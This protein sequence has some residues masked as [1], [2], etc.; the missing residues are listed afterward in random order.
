[1]II[2]F[3]GLPGAGKSTS[4]DILKNK[5]FSYKKIFSFYD[6]MQNIQ[7]IKI[8]HI[9]EHGFIEFIELIIYLKNKKM[10]YN[11]IKLWLMLKS[12]F[13]FLMRSL[14]IMAIYQFCEENYKNDIILVD[15]GIVQ[16]LISLVYVNKIKSIDTF[17]RYASNI[18][19]R[20]VYYVHIQANIN[21]SLN[22]LRTRKNQHGRL[23]K[24]QS[25]IKLMEALYYQNGL[26]YYCDEIINRIVENKN[27]IINN[28]MSIKK[29]DKQLL[30]MIKD[31]EKSTKFKFK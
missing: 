30:E 24:I 5:Y 13:S 12:P 3:Y 19:Y 18:L 22:R 1:M 9:K 20:N 31:L 14:E 15:H 27:I 4:I 28:N 25:D 16:N 23:P 8:K 17:S 21:K 6:I 2:E 7:Q 29:L 10:I 26:F 11:W